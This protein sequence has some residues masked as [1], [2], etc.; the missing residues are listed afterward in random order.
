MEYVILFVVIKEVRSARAALRNF[1]RNVF[2]AFTLDVF[3]RCE[4]VERFGHVDGEHA[5]LEHTSR[6]NNRSAL[7]VKRVVRFEE[8]VRNTLHRRNRS[9]SVL[10]AAS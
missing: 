6:R 7:V 9:V 8:S 3:A 2:I 10:F 1:G 4:H 5:I